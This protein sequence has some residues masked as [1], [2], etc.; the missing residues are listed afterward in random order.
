MCESFDRSAYRGQTVRL[1]VE[2]VEGNRAQTSFFIDDVALSVRQVSAGSDIL[3]RR[4][5]IR[6]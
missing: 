1:H 4:F 2:G 3:P 5:R 6:G